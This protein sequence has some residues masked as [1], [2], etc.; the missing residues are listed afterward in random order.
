MNIQ[1]P[2]TQQA[3]DDEP[4]LDFCLVFA[5]KLLFKEG[6]RKVCTLKSFNSIKFKNGRLGCTII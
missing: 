3:Q 4:M 1:I 2:E 5:G 6:L